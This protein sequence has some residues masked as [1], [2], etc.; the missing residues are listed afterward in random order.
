MWF[1]HVI[2][3]VRDLA[4][5]ERRWRPDGTRG[6]WR[7]VGAPDSD[8]LRE[9][10]PFFIQYDSQRRSPPPGSALEGGLR[11]VKIGVVADVFADWVGVGDLDVRCDARGSGLIAV[12][13]EVNGREVV[14]QADGSRARD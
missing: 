11:W 9:G 14:L 2:L 6:T 4:L 12:G 8:G 5:G 10:L 3:G 1:D 7:T 13:I